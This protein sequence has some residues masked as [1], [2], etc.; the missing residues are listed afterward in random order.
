MNVVALLPRLTLNRHFIQHFLAQEAPCFALALVEE[1]KQLF[2]GLALRLDVPLPPGISARGL[3]L[4][5]SLLGSACFEV[6]QLA[7]EFYGFETYH[8]LLNPN[9]PVVRTVVA[10]MIDRGGYFIL[11]IGRERD[12]TVNRHRNLTRDRRPILTRVRGSSGVA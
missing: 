11:A 10:S 5:H 8:V 2:A 7:F 3:N 1:R 9:H 6:L 4:G 12:V